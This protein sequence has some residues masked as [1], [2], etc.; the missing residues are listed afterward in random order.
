MKKGEY[1][2]TERLF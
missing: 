2:I 1:S